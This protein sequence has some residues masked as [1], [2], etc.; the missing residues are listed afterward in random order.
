MPP[1]LPLRLAR[2][3]PMLLYLPTFVTGR[4]VVPDDGWAAT[5]EPFR[6]RTSLVAAEADAVAPD[7]QTGRVLVLDSDALSLSRAD[8]PAARAI[9]RRAVLNVDPDGDFWP[10]RPSTPAAATSSAPARASTAT[11]STCS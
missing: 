9:P 4:P 6:L 5:G 1:L 3:A 10:P 7:G 11:A 8:P 2:A